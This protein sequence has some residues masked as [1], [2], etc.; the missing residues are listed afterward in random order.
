MNKVDG[1]CVCSVPIKF[2]GKRRATLSAFLAPVL[3]GHQGPDRG[4]RIN[5]MKHGAE[6]PRVLP[7]WGCLVLPWAAVGHSRMRVHTLPHAQVCCHAATRM[8]TLTHTGSPALHDP[9]SFL[10]PQVHRRAGQDLASLPHLPFCRTQGDQ[11]VLRPWLPSHPAPWCGVPSAR[12]LCTSVRGDVTGREF[13]EAA[14][15]GSPHTCWGRS[16]GGDERFQQQQ[17]ET[18]LGINGVK[19]R[20]LGEGVLNSPQTRPSP[21]QIKGKPSL[22]EAHSLIL[23][24]L[25]Q[26]ADSMKQHACENVEVALEVE[27][28]R[29]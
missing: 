3:L 18:S 13:R 8:H 11:N 7:D 1:V 25:S 21:E 19:A 5:V 27:G 29:V 24:R 26:K 2:H 12:P 9:Q 17:E 14:E 20:T 16:C 10:R 23:N 15:M 28:G 22:E 4:Q 6:P